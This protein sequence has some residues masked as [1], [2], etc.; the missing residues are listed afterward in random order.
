VL[1]YIEGINAK[2]W[3]YYFFYRYPPV[4]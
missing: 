3:I 4:L 2:K 1:L